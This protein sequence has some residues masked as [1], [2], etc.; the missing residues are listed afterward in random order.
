[1]LGFRDKHLPCLVM[2]PLMYT[3]LGPNEKMFAFLS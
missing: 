3:E 2:E 1:M